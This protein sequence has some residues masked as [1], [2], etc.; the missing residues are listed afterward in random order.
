MQAYFPIQL[1][2]HTPIN[3]LTPAFHASVYRYYSLFI[4]IIL[5]K[6]NTVFDVFWFPQLQDVTES[7]KER[8]E[9]L[10]ESEEEHGND[11]EN[12]LIQLEQEQQR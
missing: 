9:K 8:E 6:L 5:R 11:L 7:L 2:I 12:S 1:N 10:K 4:K 3:F